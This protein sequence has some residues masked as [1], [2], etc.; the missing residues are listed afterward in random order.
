MPLVIAAISQ[1]RTSQI[2]HSSEKSTSWPPSS[3]WPRQSLSSPDAVAKTVSLKPQRFR[4]RRIRRPRLN[5]SISLSNVLLNPV[6]ICLDLFLHLNSS[7]EFLGNLHTHFRT[8]ASH[9]SMANGPA[10]LIELDGPHGPRRADK[11]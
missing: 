2:S 9:L 10:D 5:S 11:R 8:F 7:H 1:R 3:I 6:R 4:A